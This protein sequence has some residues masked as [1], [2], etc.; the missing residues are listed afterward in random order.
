MNCSIQMM[1]TNRVRN[2]L[3][4]MR[5][6]WL[7]LVGL[8]L[9]GFPLNHRGVQGPERARRET[10]YILHTLTAQ[11]GGL[12]SEGCRA[13]LF[14]TSLQK[15][16]SPTNG[17]SLVGS[18]RSACPSLSFCL[19]FSGVEMAEGHSCPSLSFCLSFSGAV[20]YRRL[21]AIHF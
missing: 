5:V 1:Q 10:D 2:R 17:R 12:V 21:R 15:C 11:A 13:G 14:C 16:A 6:S 18:I 20:V 4:S 3:W 8:D 7:D 19:S 9:V